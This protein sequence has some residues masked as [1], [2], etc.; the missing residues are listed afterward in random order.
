MGNEIQKFDLI[1]YSLRG[2]D[3]D[4]KKHEAVF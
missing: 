4:A 2:V 3:G 1:T